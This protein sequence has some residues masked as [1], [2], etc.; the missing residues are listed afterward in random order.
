MLFCV[1]LMKDGY[2][3]DNLAFLFQLAKPGQTIEKKALHPSTR[4]NFEH[5]LREPGGT[6][7]TK[8][9]RELLSTEV[10]LLP[11]YQ[12]RAM[13]HFTYI[14]PCRPQHGSV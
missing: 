12:E 9:E 5:F 8:E 13:K 3:F 10:L 4:H 14:V 11:L 1:L 7:T 6:F 2:P